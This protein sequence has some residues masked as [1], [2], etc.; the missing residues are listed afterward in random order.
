MAEHRSPWIVLLAGGS[1]SR[2]RTLTKGAD[3]TPI[4]KQFWPVP[5]NR[6]ML[7]WALDRAKRLAPVERILCVVAREHERWWQ[8][9]LRALPLENVL[10]QPVDR[11]TGTA[12]LWAA[13]TALVRDREAAVAI[14]PCDH[15]VEREELLHAAVCRALAVARAPRGRIVLVGAVPRRCEV[16]CGWIV[17]G[18]AVG[19]ARTVETFVEKPDTERALGLIRRGA[20]VNTFVS[21]ARAAKLVEAF[22]RTVPDAA[23][24]FLAWSLAEPG[25]RDEV[26]SLY[27]MLPACDFS[28]SVLERVPDELAVVPVASAC[29]WADLGT[30]ERLTEHVSVHSVPA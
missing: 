6:T 5:G 22:E 23:H 25:P 3:G 7:D 4:P 17:P 27:G 9:P 12:I 18:A 28:R 1:G 30:P 16:G 2:V 14:L 15:F 26:A 10:V 29:G 11:G 19:T 8:G 20:L 13:L 24:R 21:S